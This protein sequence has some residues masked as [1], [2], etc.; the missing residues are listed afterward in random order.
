[1]QVRDGSS[2]ASYSRTVNFSPRMMVVSV[3]A[4]CGAK[5]TCCAECLRLY[6]RL[7]TQQVSLAPQ[8][9]ATET[10][11]ILGEEFTVRLYDARDDPSRTCVVSDGNGGV[12][13]QL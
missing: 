12:C 9:A 4:S 11:T 2:L 5:D 3:V 6:E 7:P 10:T 13:L 1:M 8:E